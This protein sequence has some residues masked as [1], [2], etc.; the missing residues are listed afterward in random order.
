MSTEDGNVSDINGTE[1]NSSNTDT[2][3][4][5]EEKL[6]I[7]ELFEPCKSPGRLKSLTQMLLIYI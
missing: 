3:L 2:D 7:N 6:C 4:L 1:I 5:E